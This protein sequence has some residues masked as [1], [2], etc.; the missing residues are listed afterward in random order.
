[1]VYFVSDLRGPGSGRLGD[2]LDY[3]NSL[4]KGQALPLKA[5][6]DPLDIPR[7]LPYTELIDVLYDPLDFHYR[8]L[9]TAIDEISRQSYGGLKVSEIPS[10]KEP[11]TMFSLYQKAVLSGEPSFTELD[12]VGEVVGVY[13]VKCL[14]CPMTQEP[15]GPVTCLAGCI[16][17]VGR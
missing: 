5:D 2:F 12:Y 10:Q 14:V 4:R 7:L 13:G 6:F 8:L 11:S 3:W 1:M 15:G 17:L 9:G 16:D